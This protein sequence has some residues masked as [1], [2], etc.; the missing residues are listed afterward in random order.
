MNIDSKFFFHIYALIGRF[1]ARRWTAADLCRPHGSVSTKDPNKI[2]Q[3]WS[4]EET[5]A[6]EVRSWTRALGRL[7]RS[8]GHFSEKKIV[9][10]F[11]KNNKCLNSKFLIYFKVIIGAILKY[12]CTIK[13]YFKLYYIF[14]HLFIIFHLNNLKLYSKV[15]IGAILK[16]L[17]TIDICIKYFIKKW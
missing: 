8:A 12:L 6:S 15:L 7:Q 5:V 14:I 4:S 3:R 13:I 1:C 10:G 2:Q 16:Y 17:F 11:V 9:K